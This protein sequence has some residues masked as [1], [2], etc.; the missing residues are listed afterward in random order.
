[1]PKKIPVFRSPDGEALFCE[2][3]MAILNFLTE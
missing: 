2:V 3:Y 1:M